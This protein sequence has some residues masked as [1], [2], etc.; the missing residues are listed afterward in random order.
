MLRLIDTHTHFDLPDFAH[1]QQH[2]Q[3][4]AQQ[5]GVQALV[6]IGLSAEY[7][8]RLCASHHQLNAQALGARS[9]LAPGLHPFYIAQHAPEHLQQLQQLLQQESCVAIGEIGLDTF[10]AEHKQPDVFA[11]Q[12]YYFAAQIQ[13][14]QQYQ[15]PIIL[16]IRKAHAATIAMLKQHKFA[17]GGIAHAFSGGI[18]EAKA[19]I[20]MGFK[21]GVTGQITNPNAKKLRHVV[22]AVGLPHLVIETDCPDMTPLCCQVAGQTYTRNTPVNLPAVLDGLAQCL[23]QPDRALVAAQLWQNSCDALQIDATFLTAKSLH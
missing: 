14:A 21:L 1:D 23:A 9:L 13:L 10:L 19:L 5:V 18:E 3:I 4:Q 16:H 17:H 6:H 20:K 15:L 11:Q 12:Q 22:Q 7:F 2:L 8:P